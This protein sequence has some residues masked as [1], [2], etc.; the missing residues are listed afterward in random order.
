M[1]QHFAMMAEYNRWA[2]RLLYEAAAQLTA[3]EYTRDAGAFFRSMKGTLNHILVADRIW[4]RRFT[5]E[6]EA[7]SQLDAILH[8]ALPALRLAREAEDK[9]IIG[10]VK[11]L[12]ETA[13]KGR[14]TYMTV[15]AP[16]TISQRLSPALT[17]FFNH[18]THHR[19]Q[20]HMILSVLGKSPPSL[21]LIY[22]H[23][24]PEGQPYA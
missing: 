18:Q 15:V 10:W 12:D 5:G 2:N 16:R 3:E 8:D 23:R 20:A 1:K 14:F 24:A 22:F 19:G 4:M 11:G 9:R 6:G 21:D 13:L 7:P 17:H